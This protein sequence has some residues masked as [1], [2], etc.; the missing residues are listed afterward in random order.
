MRNDVISGHRDAQIRA[1][2]IV[3]FGALRVRLGKYLPQD[4]YE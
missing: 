1:F 2:L 4:S 3:A